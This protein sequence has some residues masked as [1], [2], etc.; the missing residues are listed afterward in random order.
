MATALLMSQSHGGTIP[1][2]GTWVV[3]NGDDTVSGGTANTNSPVLAPGGTPTSVSGNTIQSAFSTLSLANVGDFVEAKGT[4]NLVRGGTQLA[5]ANRLNDQLRVGLFHATANPV[6]GTTVGNNGDPFGFIA[7]YGTTGFPG[8]TTQG[9]LRGLIADQAN[10]FSGGAA[11]PVIAPNA[12][13][14]PEGNFL[15]GTPVAANFR[16]R[17]TRGAGNTVNLTGEFSG[18]TV[19]PLDNDYFQQFSLVGHAPHATFNFTANRLAVL[20]GGNADAT[21][22]SLSN[23]RIRSN[24]IIPEP[25]SWLVAVGL[26]LGAALLYRRPGHALQPANCR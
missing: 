14:D 16:F 20:I 6:S 2:N 17:I 1:V 8:L 4:I 19:D 21:G 18:M 10:P 26:V 12:G 25:A 11:T 9:E 13:A 22:A 5:N 7:E 3:T 23:V 15:S 24:L